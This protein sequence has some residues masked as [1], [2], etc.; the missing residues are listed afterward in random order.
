MKDRKFAPADS[1]KALIL[2]F[3]KADCPRC[4]WNEAYFDQLSK[5]FANDDFIFGKMDID[6]NYPTAD[7][8]QFLYPSKEEDPML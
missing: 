1:H 6:K 2:M 5:E 3:T 4:E 7:F 8:R